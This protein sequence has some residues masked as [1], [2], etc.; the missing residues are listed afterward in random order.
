LPPCGNRDDGDDQPSSQLVEVLE[1]RH[2]AAGFLAGLLGV[3]VGI[4]VRRRLGG[5]FEGH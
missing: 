2:L 5:A 1:K 3:V 4:V